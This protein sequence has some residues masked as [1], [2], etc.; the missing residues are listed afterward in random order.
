MCPTKI[1]FVLA[2]SALLFTL[3]PAAAVAGPIIVDETSL[4]QTGK[5]YQVNLAPDGRML[6]SIDVAS[7]I[8]RIDPNTNAYTLYKGQYPD[9]TSPVDA[10]ADGA[11]NIWFADWGGDNGTLGRITGGSLTLWDLPSGYPWGV[12]IDTGGRVWVTDTGNSILYRFKPLAGVSGALTCY[13]LPAGGI[14][15]Y[16]LAAG[17]NLWLGDAWNGRILRV[18]VALDTGD[19]GA[20]TVWQIPDANPEGM[21][22]DAGGRLWWADTGLNRLA[23]LNP[24]DP[25]STVSDPVTFYTPPVAGSNPLV[26]QVSGDRIWYS[27]NGIGTAGV[28]DP[29]LAGSASIAASTSTTSLGE[30]FMPGCGTTVSGRSGAIQITN[31]SLSEKWARTFWS[32]A[33]ER[34]GWSVYRPPADPTVGKP[35]GIAVVDGVPWVVDQARRKLAR[36]NT[37]P[38]RSTFL[39]LVIRQ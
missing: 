20:V 18:R 24:D 35:Y 5:P 26:V 34:N 38:L 9:M 32:S 25:D 30:I 4:G 6:I 10:H 29:A 39:P 36:L 11:G 23:R 19:P 22:L 8:W 1:R 16:V 2:F 14:S 37:A 33:A 15:S 31:D 21:A 3:A 27:E 17:D 12:A 7:Q 28:L 13:S